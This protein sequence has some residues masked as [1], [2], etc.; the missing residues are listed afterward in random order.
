MAMPAYHLSADQIAAIVL[1]VRFTGPEVAVA[2]A[3]AESGGHTDAL[4]VNPGPPP[5]R[6]RGL[7]QINDRFHPEVTDAQAFEAVQA[8]VAAHRISR[9]GRDWSPWHAFTTGAYRA[10]LEAA[11]V[12]VVRRT[13]PGWWQ[14]WIFRPKPTVRAFS[15]HGAVSYLQSVLGIRAAQTG[16]QVSGVFDG[17]T[18]RGVR[19]VQRLFGLTV[20]GIVGS[21]QTW[22]VIDFLAAF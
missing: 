4:H 14:D 22:P 9:G 2:I 15:R 8:T 19:N 1:S 18:D 6:D 21:R 11:R 16:I 20:D 12:A 17:A 10:H 5:S 13:R 3:L 7:W